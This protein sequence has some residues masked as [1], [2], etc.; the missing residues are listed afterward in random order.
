MLSGPQFD[1][2]T[3]KL[4]VMEPELGD[5]KASVEATQVDVAALEVLVTTA[6][7]K[8]DEVIAALDTLNT[9]VGG[10]DLGDTPV[11]RAILAEAV[12]V[13]NAPLE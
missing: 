5:V 4:D 1:Y 10:I 7:T 13:R 3:G 9:S 8:L 6:N 12:G 2:F 11:L